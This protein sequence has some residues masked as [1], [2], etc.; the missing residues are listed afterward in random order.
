MRKVVQELK[1]RCMQISESTILITTV[2]KDMFLKIISRLN[3]GLAQIA[4]VPP[5][6]VAYYQLSFSFT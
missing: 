4:P 2:V 6:V 3:H 5:D 1:T